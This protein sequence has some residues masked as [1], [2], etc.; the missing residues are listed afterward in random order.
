MA[1]SVKITDFA[2]SPKAKYK[3]QPDSF[4]VQKHT[5]VLTVLAKSSLLYIS[6]KFLQTSGE[7]FLWKCCVVPQHSVG[8]SETQYHCFIF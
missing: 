1:S 4:T 2:Q 8:P 5:L 3:C 7:I 6:P